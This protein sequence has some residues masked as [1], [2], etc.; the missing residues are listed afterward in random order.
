LTAEAQGWLLSETGAA[1]LALLDLNHAAV[2]DA[3]T[4]PTAHEGRFSM[5]A[6]T[7][8]RTYRLRP[9]TVAMLD[10]AVERLGIPPKSPA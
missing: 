9:G 2:L 1:L 4:R 5:T 7:V 8:T 10:E 6:S 3:L